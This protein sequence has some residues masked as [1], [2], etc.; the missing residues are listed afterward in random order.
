MQQWTCSRCSAPSGQTAPIMQCC[1][2]LGSRPQWSPAFGIHPL[3]Q[4]TG[5]TCEWI[6]FFFYCL[7]SRKFLWA[8]FTWR[9]IN[10]LFTMKS[11]YII[12]L[13]KLCE[14]IVDVGSFRQEKA[15]TWTNVIKEKKLLVLQKQNVKRVMT[16]TYLFIITHLQYARSVY[17]SNPSVVPPSSLFLFSLPLLHLPNA[18]KSYT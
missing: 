14:A 2:K 9:L 6:F 10:T 18:W 15:T 12:H 17:F 11:A 3:R 4:H 5:R 1:T 7:N 13:Y 8:I 16:R